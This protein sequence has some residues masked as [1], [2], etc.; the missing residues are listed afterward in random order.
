[1]SGEKKATGGT[2]R[3]RRDTTTCR[4]CS[5]GAP[6]PAPAA[7]RL[8]AAVPPD[9]TDPG[10]GGGASPGTRIVPRPRPCQRVPPP[11]LRVPGGAR[12]SSAH[13]L[14]FQHAPERG[15]RG[16]PRLVGWSLQSPTQ[17]ARL[18]PPQGTAAP[19][20]PGE[21]PLGWREGLSLTLL[22]LFWSQSLPYR[23]WWLT[24]RPIPFS[25]ASCR[26]SSI[27]QKAARTPFPWIWN[28]SPLKSIVCQSLTPFPCKIQGSRP[29]S[30]LLLQRPR[31]GGSQCPPP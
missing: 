19:S 30:L 24:P 29:L 21:K 14:G 1:M 17:T 27:S 7:V 26:H 31:G 11:L 13:S 22:S 20:P 10:R 15:F 28:S 2:C 12:V 4:C 5:L 8:S 6:L 18:H 25:G 23:P 16:G 3:Q 9:L